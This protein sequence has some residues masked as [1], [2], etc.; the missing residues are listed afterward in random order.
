MSKITKLLEEKRGKISRP[1]IWQWMLRND[2]KSKRNKKT[3]K[4]KLVF[5]KIK[6]FCTSKVIINKVKR[7]NNGRKY[8]K[9]IYLIGVY[10]PEYIKNSYNW[11]MKRQSNWKMDKGLEQTLIQIN[12]IIS[13]SRMAIQ[14]E[15]KITNVYKNVQKLESLYIANWNVKWPSCL[16]DILVV[17]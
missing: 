17:L 13:P 15:W 6:D 10:Y 3:K 8:L 16:G 7:I 11:I 9:I 2:F 12:Y 14:S 4:D 1:C 5:I